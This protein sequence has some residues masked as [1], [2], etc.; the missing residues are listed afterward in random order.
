MRLRLAASITGTLFLCVL[1]FPLLSSYHNPHASHIDMAQGLYQTSHDKKYKKFSQFPGF[2][3][4][5]PQILVRTFI[6]T[7]PEFDNSCSTQAAAI[8]LSCRA[9]PLNSV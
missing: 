6:I 7:T 2:H 9:P 4:T 8:I 1:G 5:P 3:P